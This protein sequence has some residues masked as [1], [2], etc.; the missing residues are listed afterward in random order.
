MRRRFP[1]VMATTAAAAITLAA[2]GGGGGEADDAATADTAAGGAGGD[3]TPVTVGVIPIVDTAAIWLGVEQGIFEEHGLDVNL[4][5]A[6]GGAAIVPAV[7]SGDYD[8]GFSNI[9]SLFVASDQGLP[10]KLLTPGNATTGD[11]DADIGAVVVPADSDITGTAD[12]AGRTIAVNTL[13]N[14][15]DVTVSH[16]VSEAGG[17]AE[18]IQFVEM[19]FPDMPAA[20]ANGQVDAAWILEPFL[21]IAKDQGARMVTSNFAETDPDLLIAGYFTTAQKAEAEPEVVEAFTAAM[22]ESLEYAEANPDEA[23]AILSTYTEIDPAV[24]EAMAMPRF[25]SELDQD[26]LQL[27]ADLSLEYGLV[28]NEVDLEALQ[29]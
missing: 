26:A 8:F 29:R 12:L 2:C 13:N 20:V 17:D 3:P 27:L 5:V 15:G 21:T 25:P 10:L 28:E 1:L 9:V 23:R 7:V 11:P 6:Q 16:V 22:T 14:I 19:G 24:Q 4:E 18:S